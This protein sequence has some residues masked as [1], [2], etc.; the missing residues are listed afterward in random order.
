MKFA[1]RMKE[2]VE[3]GAAAGKDLAAKAGEKAKELGTKG[4]LK[5]EILQ[6]QSRAEKLMSRLGSEV[7]GALVEDNKASVA[8]NDPKI[9][10]TLKE[11]QGIQASIEAKEKE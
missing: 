7:Y 9:S 1:D 6:L 11:I 8:R 10:A 2:L 5:V 3:K 4:K